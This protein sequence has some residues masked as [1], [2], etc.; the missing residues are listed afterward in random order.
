MWHAWE[1]TE[2][3]RMFGGKA[4]RK[5]LLRRPRRRLEDGMKTGLSETALGGGGSELSWLGIVTDGEL[6]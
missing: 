4:Q 6:L 3:C 2:K 5:E 1:R